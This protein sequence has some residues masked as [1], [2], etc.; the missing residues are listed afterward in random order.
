M[1]ISNCCGAEASYISDELCGQCLEWAV[2]TDEDED[3]KEQ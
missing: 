1:S 3:E 2:F